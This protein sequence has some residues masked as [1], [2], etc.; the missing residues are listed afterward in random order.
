MTFDPEA[1][2]TA[3]LMGAI[4]AADPASWPAAPPAARAHGGWGSVALN[5]AV[6]GASLVGAVPAPAMAAAVAVT[7]IPSVR[8]AAAALRDKRLGVDLLDPGRHRHLDRHRPAADRRLHPT[9]LLGIGDLVLAKTHDQAR[10]AISKLMRL[11]AHEAFRVKMTTARSSA[12]PSSESPWADH[13]IVEAGGQVAW[14]TASS[15]SA[16]SR[17]STRRR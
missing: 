15:S 2:N 3:R 9:W 14:P 12:S 17:W 4:L 6:L 13:L 8:R 11:D 7:A 1:T 10:S 5:T 16:A